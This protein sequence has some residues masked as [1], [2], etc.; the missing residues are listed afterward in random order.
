MPDT[1]VLPPKASDGVLTVTAS[2]II[3]APIEKV[4]EVLLDFSSYPEWYVSH[5]GDE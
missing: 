2:S 4:W 5:L 1:P 3:D